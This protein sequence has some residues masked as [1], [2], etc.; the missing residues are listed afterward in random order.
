[1]ARLS[2]SARALEDLERLTSFLEEL[3]PGAAPAALDS[4]IEA[5]RVLVEHPQ[6]GRRL[7]G[8]LREL[9]ISRGITGYLALYE[10]DAARDAVEILHLRHQREAGYL[11]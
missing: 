11:D 7:D 3:V 9:V 1:V 4:I 5:L 6:I 2:F 8:D 10:Y